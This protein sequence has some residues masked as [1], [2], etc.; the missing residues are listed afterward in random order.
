[1]SDYII[2][3]SSTADLTEEHFKARNIS[4]LQASAYAQPGEAD[5]E[6]LDESGHRKLADAIYEKLA[7]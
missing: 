7:C 2:S 5:Q 3:C 4:Y 6:H 1:M